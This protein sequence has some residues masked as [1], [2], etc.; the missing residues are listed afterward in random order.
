MMWYILIENDVI[1]LEGDNYN[2]TDDNSL[3]RCPKCAEWKARE[4]FSRDRTKKDG[5]HSH[6]KACV[7]SKDMSEYKR[8]YD[9]ENADKIRV[10]KQAYYI[11]NKE[12]IRKVHRTYYL[13]NTET[14][15]RRQRV[16]YMNNREEILALGREREKGQRDMR[17][18]ISH[19]RRAR[20]KANGGN[21][22]AA[23][24]T[25]MRIA[26]AGVCAYCK[27]QLDPDDLTIDHIIP[28]DQGGPHIISN[29]C[30]ACG[31]CNS[32][33]GNRT[34]EQWT[35]RWYLRDASYY[36]PKRKKRPDANSSS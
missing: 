25:A 6:C 33:K 28:F 3:K 21:V 9:I 24:L 2:M 36:R 1:Y 5:Y 29:I 26:Q 35:D 17:R 19:R 34:P 15:L 23:E 10:R 27:R 20:K 8:N 12:R 30:L 22:T 32:S 31:V 16:R 18:A 13:A 4:A 11:A 14:T 7:N